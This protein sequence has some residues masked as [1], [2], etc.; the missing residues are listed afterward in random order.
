MKPEECGRSLLAACA[1][2][3]D[4]RAR[5]RYGRHSPVPALLALATAALLAGARRL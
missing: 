1:R 4:A 3:P 5:S 2:V